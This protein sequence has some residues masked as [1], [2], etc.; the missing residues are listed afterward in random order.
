MHHGKGSTVE[1]ILQIS[2]FQE[3]SMFLASKL[4]NS[5]PFHLISE[6]IHPGI[7]L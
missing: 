6:L 4:C 7:F 3:L 5:E 1:D 2:L